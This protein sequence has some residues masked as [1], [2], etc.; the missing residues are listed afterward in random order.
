MAVQFFV[1]GKLLPLSK[2]FPA[3]YRDHFLKGGGALHYHDQTLSISI[4]EVETEW[5]AFSILHIQF[6]KPHKLICKHT[7]P[8][9]VLFARTVLDHPA[10]EWLK[11][12]GI[13]HY[14]ENQFACLFGINWQSL[15]APH[16]A[17]TYVFFDMAW[18]EEL[19]TYKL[20]RNMMTRLENVC[21]GVPNRIDAGRLT[22]SMHMYKMLHIFRHYNYSPDKSFLDL[23]MHRYLTLLITRIQTYNHTMLNIK[24]EH[25][26]AVER[27]CDF[28]Y[29]NLDKEFTIPEL[30][31]IALTNPTNLKR[32]FSLIIGFTIDDFKTYLRLSPT[33][34]QLAFTDRQVKDIY[35][36]AHYTSASAFCA[37]FR[38]VFFC[39]PTEVRSD[40]WDTSFI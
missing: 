32:Y 23:N 18:K 26:K 13:Q 27:A 15:L 31:K 10:T 24:E 7:Y 21:A 37:G 3:N 16:K 29:N 22:L 2:G 14:H 9:R 17:T 1:D 33:L 20:K 34:S 8:E 12:G 36:M 4:Q 6:A 28:I 19:L 11:G 38:K 5:C 39:T 25:W 35:S 30:S 40:S